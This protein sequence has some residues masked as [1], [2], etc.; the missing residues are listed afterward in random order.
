[1]VKSTIAVSVIL[2]SAWTCGGQTHPPARVAA[3][4]ATWV[5]TNSVPATNEIT[6][7]EFLTEVTAANLDYAAQRYNVSIAEA[8]IAAAKE[9]QNPILQLSGGRDVTHTGSERLPSTAGAALTQTIALGG[10][11]KYRILAARQS[12]AAAAATLD[13]FL[14]NLRLD[15]AAAFADALALSRSA[16]QKSQSAG[17]L[18]HLAETQRAR[19]RAGDISEAEM[20]QTQVEEQR[21]QNELLSTQADAENASLAL[22]GFLGRD[23]G[24]SRLIPKGNL[25]IPARDFDVA[26]LLAGALKN[27]ADLVA[28][29]H[30]RDAAQ[31]N[32]RLE[33]ANRVPNMDVGPSWTH[34][35][36]SQ[37]SIA[38]APEFDSVG[39]S[40]SFPLPLWNRNKAAIASA[41]FSG[42]QAQKQL[43]AAELKAEV[44]IRQ[45]FSAYR[46]A[47]ERHRHYEN[48]ILKDADA[49]LEAKRFSYQHGQ[50]TLLEL[51][52]AQRTDNE[53]RSGYND[54][55]ADHAKALIELERA[56]QLWEIQF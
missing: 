13:G 56:A 17:F 45:A 39:M 23:R 47:V 48:G 7:G 20:L 52:D 8:A 54:A 21:F 51:L 22:S 19:R 50:T 27:R 16:E 41:R 12:Y 53:V 28:L 38:P 32:V 9:F 11:R 18:S 4:S 10:K 37:N 29:R 40:F 25:G 24:Q 42:E 5:V 30:A 26:A 3:P 35:T 31:S 33:K 6:F 55:L 44:Q 49:V 14:R 43:E 2:I 36:S 34:N 15:A 1:M 46:S